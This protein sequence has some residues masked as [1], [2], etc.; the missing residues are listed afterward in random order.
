MSYKLKEADL[1]VINT[2]LK[3]LN[4]SKK[5]FSTR[6]KSKIGKLAHYIWWF[7]NYNLQKF[8]IIK[9]KKQLIFFWYKKVILK[10]K[11][12]FFSGWWPINKIRID[13]IF[14]VTR[15]LIS[16][17]K[18]HDHI[19]L[20]SRNNKF[21]IKLHHYFKFKKVKEHGK[22]YNKILKL[23]NHDNIKK[24]KTIVR[25]TVMIKKR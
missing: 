21:S 14:F 15:K 6:S 13:D 10:K 24:K 18:D 8:C 12:Y 9:N 16:L 19:A 4:D 17:S 23:V 11:K 20:I 22:E 1:R 5:D 25:Y 7:K 2:Y 3:S